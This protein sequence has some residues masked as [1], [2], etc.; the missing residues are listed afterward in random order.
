MSC[1]SLYTHGVKCQRQIEIRT[2]FTLPNIIVRITDGGRPHCVRDA[3]LNENGRAA[4]V[5]CA[6]GI[7]IVQ[8]E[9]KPALI[10]CA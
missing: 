9:V 3:P 8:Q 5:R 10:S 7:L 6:C 1:L 4:D 2:M